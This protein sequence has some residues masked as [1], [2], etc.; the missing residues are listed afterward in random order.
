MALRDGRGAGLRRVA[1]RRAGFV[2]LA[3]A[4]YLAGGI[5]ATWPAVLHARSHFLSGGAPSHGDASPGDH[6]QTLWHYWLV[7]HQL[8]HG[9]A[10]W[11]DPYTF[12]PEAKPQANYA[13][14][15]FGF[16]FWP[17]SAVFGL[18]AGWNL[19]QLVIYVLAGL[20]AC[21][22]LREL[23]LPRGPALAGGLVFAIAPYRV[24]QSV[25]HLLGPISILLPLSLWAFE[26]GW[27][28]LSAAALASIPLSGQVHLA[29]GA[30]PFVLA[31]ALVRRRD[32]RAVVAAVAGAL[33]AIG[34]GLLVRETLIK[35]ST[36]AGGRKLAEITRYSAHVGDLVSRSLDPGRSEQ[37]VFL[38]WLTPLLALAGLVFLLRGRR[39][40]L[41]A[42]LALGVVIPVVLALG[43]NTPI[44]SPLWHALPPFRFPRVPERL[45]PIACLCLA[46]LVAF[47]LARARTV[48]VAAVIAL[49]FVDLHAHVYRQSAVGHPD[50]VAY[51]G[52]GR[53]LEL[54]IFDPSVHYGSVYLWYDTSSQRERPSGYSTTA[55]RAAKRTAD[56]LERLNC[57]DWSDDTAGLLERL[58]VRAIAVHLGLYGP[59]EHSGAFAV[60]SLSA[61]GWK[62]RRAAGSVLLFERST[63]GS[64]PELRK[65]AEAF[66]HFCVGWYPERG[67]GRYMSETHAALWVYSARRPRL[68]FAPTP[69]PP[70]VT[71]HS[72]TRSGWR[73][74]TVDVENLRR[75]HGLKPR[76]GARLLGVDLQGSGTS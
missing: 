36:E 54:P 9:H 5:A 7:G 60:D 75:V 26:R 14:W 68:R 23:G 6:L 55:P 61:R 17:L 44:Y 37:F 64:A 46:A 32:R 3:A 28:W 22:W 76:V 58:R 29:L 67:G 40:G 8:E 53:V 27:F 66:P 70:R 50:R 34:A 63:S 65:P 1:S 45:L 39:Y 30:I 24:Q 41:A 51:H 72:R 18:V 4:L 13:G 49:L 11:R 47:A 25:G 69:F 42:V 74:V 48:V 62:V 15:P 35:G 12:R 43:T 57:G 21:A 38:G 56:R 33:L 19:L 52:P 71:V 59:E 16:L 73:L 10:P 31:Y 20:F 2:A